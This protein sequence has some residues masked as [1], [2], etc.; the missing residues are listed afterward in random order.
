MDFELLFEAL[1]INAEN[2]RAE[3]ITKDERQGFVQGVFL[4]LELLGLREQYDEWCI[5]HDILVVETPI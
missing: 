1:C 4:T 5:K 3:R 2:A